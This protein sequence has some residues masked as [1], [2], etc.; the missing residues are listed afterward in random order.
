[1]QH[2]E[3]ATFLWKYLY[4]SNSKLNL[5]ILSN[6]LVFLLNRILIL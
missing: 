5:N 3:K 4:K 2:N 6:F 1:M